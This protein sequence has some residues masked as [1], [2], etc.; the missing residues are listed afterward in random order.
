MFNYFLGLV[1]MLY[2]KE[3]SEDVKITNSQEALQ[4]TQQ[5]LQ[6]TRQKLQKTQEVL[7]T[8]EEA[9]LKN[10][11]E[12]QKAQEAMLKN[13]EELLSVLKKVE[14]ENQSLKITNNTLQKR[15]VI[16]VREL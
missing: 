7:Q 15:T 1:R 2:S 3:Y 12:L 4:K 5:K 16:Q 10:K 14:E 9:L 11:E 13:K 8:T 6:K